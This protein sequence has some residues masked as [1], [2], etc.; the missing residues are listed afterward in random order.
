M[1]DFLV[2]AIPMFCFGYPF[3]MAWYWMAGGA[4][5]YITREWSMPPQDHPDAMASWP[6][7]S[8]LVPCY[9][10]GGQCRGDTVDGGRGRLPGFRGHRHQRRQP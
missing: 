3:V 9:N 5:F 8:I 2:V 7:I 1:L 4:L 10:E 6:P